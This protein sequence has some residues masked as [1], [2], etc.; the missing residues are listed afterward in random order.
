MTAPVN[1]DVEDMVTFTA[2]GENSFLGK[3]FVPQKIFSHNIYRIALKFC[4]T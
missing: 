4:G 1:D 3:L 2:S